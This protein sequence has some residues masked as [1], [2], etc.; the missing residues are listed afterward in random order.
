[1]TATA[2]AT[3]PA[4]NRRSASHLGEA[5]AVHQRL[6][7]T[8]HPLPHR[9]SARR[10]RTSALSSLSGG[11]EH[12]RD[13]GIV[14]CLSRRKRVEVSRTWLQ[15]EGFASALPYHA[16]LPSHRGIRAHNQERF[17]ARGRGH[18]CRHH[19]FRHGHRQ[20]GRALCCPP[21]TCPRAVEAYYQ[22]TGR[23][24]PGR[25]AGECL[26]GLWA[27]GRDHASPDDGKFGG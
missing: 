26:D 5:E 15:D 17:P 4:R 12:P 11:S 18:R 2:D 10:R 7:Q 9:H 23:G 3:H 13:A 14:Y 25:P 22:E 20:T 24:R 1:M 6:R 19:R 8:Q 27:P 16:G 21:G